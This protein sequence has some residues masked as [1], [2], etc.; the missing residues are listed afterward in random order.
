VN[1]FDRSAFDRIA[2]RGML[3]MLGWEPWDYRR[4]PVQQHLRGEQRE[5]QLS[6]IITGHFD[7]Y[8]RSWARG[9]KD[10]GYPVAIRFAHE[11]NGN[12]YPW[13]EQANGNAAGEYVRA[14]RHVHDLFTVEGASHVV[15]VW[16]PNISYENSTP[17]ANLYPGDQFVDWV[18]LSGYYG[19]AG[20]Q[21]YQTFDQIFNPTIAELRAFT[22]RP[23]VITE[24]AATD[25]AGRKAEWVRNFLAAVPRHSDIIGF[26]WYEAVKETDWRIAGSAAGKAFAAGVSGPRYDIQWSPNSVARTWPGSK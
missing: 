25:R 23:L 19:T 3:P 5:Y 10:L 9:I 8:I 11:M 7:Q 14:W 24:V 18:G 4:E 2:N 21:Q 17:L 12:W 6:H 1:R 22:Q 20:T 26:I 15:W 13:C 16:S